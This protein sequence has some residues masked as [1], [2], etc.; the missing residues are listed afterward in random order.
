LNGSDL[1][2]DNLLIEDKN[3]FSE[4]D[5]WTGNGFAKT[6]MHLLKKFSVDQNGSITYAFVALVDLAK[7]SGSWSA[8]TLSTNRS[9]LKFKVA[10]KKFIEVIHGELKAKKVY[11]SPI[12]HLI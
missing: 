4:S 8:K 10:D 2:Y 7:C 6:D 11:L 12:Q 1:V 3:S 9:E 5:S